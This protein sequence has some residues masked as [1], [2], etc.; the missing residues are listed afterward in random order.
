MATENEKYEKFLK[1]YHLEELTNASDLESV[2][3]I[4][5][6]NFGTGLLEV[7]MTLMNQKGKEE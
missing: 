7:G 6:E 4:Y 5:Y 3:K 1:K 2:R